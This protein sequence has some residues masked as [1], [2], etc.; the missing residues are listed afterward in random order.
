MH[1][2]GIDHGR[3]CRGHVGQ[4]DRD[5][6]LDGG[7]RG[8]LGIC[9][10]D[11]VAAAGRHFLHVG[12]GLLEHPVERRDHNDRHVLVDQC[13]R[14]V[15]EFASGVAFGVDVGDFLQLQRAFQRQRIAGAA[16]EIEHVF[17]FSDV[18]RE[19]LDLRFDGQRRGH[20]PRDFHQTMH[21]LDFVGIGQFA[22]RLAGGHR[23]RGQHHQLAREGL[24]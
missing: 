23:E 2:D 12:D 1:R 7:F 8:S 3:K 20:Q 4:D 21:E 13:D 14:P 17:R 24:G 16:A 22:A 18:A 11:D 6:R 5:Q 15:L 9:H 10:Q 19:L